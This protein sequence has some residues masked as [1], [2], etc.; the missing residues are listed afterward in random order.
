MIVEVTEDVPVGDDFCWLTLGQISELL[1]ADNVVNMDTRTVL[2]GAPMGATETGAL[3]SDTEVL[4]W[5]TAERCRREVRTELKPRAEVTGW[6]RDEW[7]IDHQ[8]GRY[9]SVIAVSVTAC[10]R[11]VS[12]WTRPLFEPQRAGRHCVPLPAHLR[13]PARAG[14]RQG[15]GGLPRHSRARADRMPDNY[16]HLTGTD[17][18]LFLDLVLEAPPDRVRYSVVHSE[19]GGRFLNAVSRYL[20]VD[21]DEADAPLTPPPGFSGSLRD[22]SGPPRS[23]G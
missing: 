21:A 12:G 8:E 22:S 7:L 20:I 1:R 14:A 19:E 16:A 4:S 17:R 3:H 13:E 23:L 2:S 11:E 18:P 5:F 15:R 6:T 10:S 9:F